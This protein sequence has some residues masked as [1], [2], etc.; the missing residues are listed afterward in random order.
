[1]KRDFRFII[2][3]LSQQGNVA[4]WGKTLLNQQIMNNRGLFIFVTP[5]VRPLSRQEGKNGGE[6][7]A[8]NILTAGDR[9][10]LPIE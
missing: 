4:I 10:E 3:T 7:P 5:P 6:R 8:G 9:E 1:M 2:E